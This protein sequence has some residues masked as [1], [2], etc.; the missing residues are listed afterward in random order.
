MSRPPNPYKD[1]FTKLERQA[2][3]ESGRG[4]L[5]G[6]NRLWREAKE[7]KNKGIAEVNAI[8]KNRTKEN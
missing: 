7:L 6:A 3:R 4:N 8:M 2:N 1:R 5:A